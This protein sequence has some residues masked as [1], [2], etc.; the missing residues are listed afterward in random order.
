MT[1][2]NLYER[3]CL[4]VL[5]L[6][7][8]ASVSSAQT[9]TTLHSFD[10][11]DGATPTF[12][13]LTQ[14]LDG[15][16]YG[17]TAFGGGGR[18]G[19]A[20]GGGTV[21]EIS[22]GGTLTTL[23]IFCAEFNCPE[24]ETPKGGLAQNTKGNFLGTAQ[25]GDGGS[26]T[27]FKITPGDALSRLGK[28]DH[29]SEPIGPPVQT[30]DGNFYGT[31]SAGGLGG[32]TIFKMDAAGSE[33]TTVYEFCGKSRCPDGRAPLAGLVQAT[34]GNLYGTTSGGG[35]ALAGTVFKLSPEGKFA[36]LHSF[37]TTDGSY[38]YAGL[39]QATDGN[40]YG[41]TELGGANGGGTIFQMTSTGTLTTL[42]SFCAQVSCTDGK[43]PVAG[44]TQATDG[45]FYGTTEFGGANGAGTIFQLTPGG[46]L[47]TLYSFCAQPS[48]ADGGNPLSGLLQATDGNLYGAAST[49]GASDDGT[50]FSLVIGLGPFVKTVP[51]SGEVEAIAY[52]LGTN[53]TG[54]TNVTFNGTAAAFIVVSSSEIEAKIPSGATTG[55]VTVTTPSGTLTSN[56]QFRINP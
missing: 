5:V 34:D 19:G 38:P 8:M 42:Y 24:G 7:A 20:K 16:L 31:T 15:N 17:T 41:T 36:R 53:L 3:A 10:D 52:I 2:M 12:P 11:S 21:F 32:G 29:G 27:V 30:S 54:T 18:F 1:K 39:V 44:L 6:S 37:D 51:T 4:V 26:G 43:T 49:G 9:F 25:R 35:A 33:I 23:Y 56:K 48:C 13:S 28:P 47:T 22:P 50:I 55:F 46:T 45:N 40:F 14:G